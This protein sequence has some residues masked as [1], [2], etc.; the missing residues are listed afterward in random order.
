MHVWIVNTSVGTL[1]LLYICNGQR[2]VSY[3]SH[4]VP[5]S[6][7]QNL[8]HMF[9]G[10][11]GL[12]S[13]KKEELVC[14][15]RDLGEQPRL[16]MTRP[17]VLSRV[18]QLMPKDMV[19]ELPG[20]TGKTYQQLVEL[21]A[22]Q[23]VP[24]QPGAKKADIIQ[25]IVRDHSQ[26]KAAIPPSQRRVGFGRHAIKT[27]TE[28]LDLPDYCNHVVYVYS[29]PNSNC[30]S[31]FSDLAKFLQDCGVGDD[32]DDDV[33]NKA[34]P[35][36]NDDGTRAPPKSQSNGKAGPVNKMAQADEDAARC[37]GVDDASEP[38]VAFE[39]I[40][41]EYLTDSCANASG[42]VVTARGEQ[43]EPVI[44]DNDDPWT[45]EVWTKV[46]HHMTHGELR[47]LEEIV[48]SAQETLQNAEDYV[49]MRRSDK[50]RKR[51][52]QHCK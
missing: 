50:V 11:E 30:S 48:K 32:S 52:A 42:T 28:I 8:R 25:A 23:N 5:L 43:P 34:P 44:I 2:S 3:S 14:I 13:M 19:D 29:L 7:A 16:G 31:R 45:W 39:M 51:F 6:P 15:L 46:I 41:S 17:E 26:K 20:L 38:T 33:D 9:V 35:P 21:A 12:G 1:C 22:D 36:D 49:A 27:W 37:V 47:K 4:R 24:L 18:K 40:S 10:I